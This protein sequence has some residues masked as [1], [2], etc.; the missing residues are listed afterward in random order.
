MGR[1]AIV[2]RIA[3]VGPIILLTTRGAWQV[4]KLKVQ[5]FEDFTPHVPSYVKGELFF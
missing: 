5:Q 4:G 2:G 1:V 3:N